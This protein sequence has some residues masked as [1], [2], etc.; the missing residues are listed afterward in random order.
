MKSLLYHLKIRLIHYW[1]H[2]GS[3]NPGTLLICKFYSHQTVFLKF[4]CRLQD[5]TSNKFFFQDPSYQASSEFNRPLL[6]SKITRVSS[7]FYKS[8]SKSVTF[9]LLKSEFACLVVFLEL[10]QFSCEKSCWKSN[11]NICLCKNVYVSSGAWTL[12]TVHIFV[13]FSFSFYIA[14][15]RLRVKQIQ[16][17]LDVSN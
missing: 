10:C 1:I 3:Y 4:P 6:V 7:K 15:R 9:F 14:F 2:L 13:S 16:E 5:M 17:L 11:F 8:N 12:Q